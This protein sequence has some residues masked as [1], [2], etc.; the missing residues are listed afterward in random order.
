MDK[1]TK[2]IIGGIAVAFMAYVLFRK[3][4]TSP[5]PTPNPTPVTPDPIITDPILNP[6]PV[7]TLPPTS[8]EDFNKMEV[9]YGDTK[10]SACLSRSIPTVTLYFKESGISP[11]KTIFYTDSSHTTPIKSGYYAEKFDLC[12][13]VGDGGLLTEMTTC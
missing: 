3:P 5:A 1:K 12:F 8:E 13:Y 4:K 6:L 2:L 10:E 11:N 9:A 7:D